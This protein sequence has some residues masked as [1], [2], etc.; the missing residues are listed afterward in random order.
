MEKFQCWECGYQSCNE[1]DIKIH[2]NTVHN[3]KVEVGTLSRKFSCSIC[4]FG[5]RNMDEYKKHLI[6]I[7]KK[8]EHNWMVGEI[9]STFPCDRCMMEFSDRY[10]LVDH[11]NDDYCGDWINP[12]KNFEIPKPFKRLLPIPKIDEEKYITSIKEIKPNQDFLTN[13]T[14]DLN[15]CWR[16][17]QKRILSMMKT[18]LKKILSWF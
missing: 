7:H 16:L 15:C 17:F 3:N 6:I 9:K 11:I 5:T 14:A 12:N 13:N 18:Y 4:T 10:M 2:M 8:E 1:Q